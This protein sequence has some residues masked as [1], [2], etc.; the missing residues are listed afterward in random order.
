[1]DSHRRIRGLWVYHAE[2][3]AKPVPK[4]AELASVGKAVEITSP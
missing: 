1:M 2:E 4:P 3:R